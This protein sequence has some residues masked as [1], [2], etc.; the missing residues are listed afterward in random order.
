MSNSVISG[1]ITVNIATLTHVVAHEH[2]MKYVSEYGVV[3][4]PQESC[5]NLALKRGM[6]GLFR[7]DAIETSIE[8]MF[9]GHAVHVLN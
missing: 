8:N 4:S 1:I 6:F 9:L 3:I 5:D 7:T 2:R